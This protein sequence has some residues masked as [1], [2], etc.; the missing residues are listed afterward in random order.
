MSTTRFPEDLLQAFADGEV[1]A[2]IGAGLSIQAGL[3]SWEMLVSEMIQYCETHLQNF[4]VVT[5]LLTMSQKG[6]LPEA[7]DEC[8]ASMGNSLFQQFLIKMF[9]SR[10]ARPTAVHRI[11][12]QLPFQALL[13]TNYDTLLEQARQESY[14]ERPIPPVY[15]QQNIPQLARVASDRHFYILK[16]H[17]Q[18]DDVSSIVLTANDYEGLIERN[19][20][21]KVGLSAL[22]A[23]RTLLFIGYGLQD[24]DLRLILREHAAVFKNFGRRHFA[25]VADPGTVMVRSLQQ[26]F[27]INVIPYSG[28]AN[29]AELLQMLKLLKQSVADHSVQVAAKEIP[30]K[31]ALREFPYKFL[32]FFDEPDRHLF[33]GR[34]REA[35]EF[36]EHVKAHNVLI[37]FGQS[38]AGKTSL[39]K[40]GVMPLVASLGYAIV[41]CRFTSR[42]LRETL[43]DVVQHEKHV[44]VEMSPQ[45]L[46]AS[47]IEPRMNHRQLVVIFD[48]MEHIF[49]DNSQ[50]ISFFGAFLAALIDSRTHVV[51]SLRDDYFVNLNDL[52]P[53]IPTIFNNRYRLGVLTQEGALAA[54]RNPAESIGLSCDSDYVAQLIEDLGRGESG[55]I[56]PPQLQIVCTA[57]FRALQSSSSHITIGLYRSLGGAQ[58]LIH[59]YIG[60]VL[61]SFHESDRE[62]AR[63]ILK[64]FVSPLRTRRL[65]KF[66]QILSQA[67]ERGNSADLGRVLD[68]LIS[69]RLIRVARVNDQVGYEL[70]HDYMI[71]HIDKWISEQEREE[72][73]ARDVMVH[74]REV[75]QYLDTVIP[76]ERARYLEGH[77]GRVDFSPRDIALVRRSIE[78]NEA[79]NQQQKQL[80]EQFLRA[81][82]MEAL[83]RLAG[84]IAHD[85]SNM[86]S[87]ISGYAELLESV[88]PKKDGPLKRYADKIIESTKRASEL[89]Q[90]LLTFSR[91]EI[92]RSIHFDPDRALGGLATILRR[93]V[94]EDIDIKID[95]KAGVSIIIDP[96]QFE[97]IVF[98]IVINSRDAMPN[99]GTIRIGTSLVEGR[100]LQG[101]DNAD[102][103]KTYV[104]I[105]ITDTGL[106]MNQDVLSHLFEPFFTTKEVGR[107]TGLGLST[108]YGI[109]KQHGGAIAVHSEINVGTTVEVFLPSVDDDVEI[110]ER[111]L[112][113]EGLASLA[114]RKV[115]VVDDESGI[116]EVLVS[117]LKSCGCEV[118]G[119]ANADEALHT[120]NNLEKLDIL[121]TDLIMPGMSGRKLA[122]EVVRHFPAVSVLFISGYMDSIDDIQ[123][124]L[125]RKVK[126]LPKSFSLA[127]LRQVLSQFPQDDEGSTLSDAK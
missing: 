12:C 83:G 61:S 125:S 124:L 25:F 54:I 51:L 53:F 59:S 15:T 113:R 14:P 33:Y 20:A 2:V 3:P 69:Q 81:Q 4:S 28:D 107:G 72:V 56:E 60:L 17:G 89:T 8:R 24:K 26:Q 58:T 94:G 16:L 110:A 5:E 78:V 36:T 43:H 32:D 75:C 91:K 70:P 88:L 63:S 106:G 57:V 102:H 1:L 27:N 18:I 103:A 87:V 45:S 11:L 111:A 30:G 48:Q 9:R 23:A 86:L 77:I 126:C 31:D 101:V 6:L 121:V 85:F 64:A 55:G 105:S 122:A 47:L 127:E 119:A 96:S 98:N 22:F 92:A 71:S 7:A 40:A 80:E 52:T 114:G 76:I 123:P 116:C 120:S 37:L 66:D 104:R 68:A 100:D 35:R 84:G 19:H 42:D 117:F 82:K 50:H 13:T 90:Q 29:H 38:G 93:L 95:S 115:L 41:Y 79:A 62:I 74:E 10:I 21:Y 67:P 44:K 108:C 99:G 112:G 46:A 109:V 39:L 73:R 49:S 118:L 65:L 97:Q 34:E